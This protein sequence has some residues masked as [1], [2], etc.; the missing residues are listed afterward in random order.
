MNLVRKDSVLPAE[1]GVIASYPDDFYGYFGWPTVARMPGG[2]LVA[3]ASGLRNHHVCPFGRSV[4]FRS[5]DEGRSWTSPR[6]V[7][8]SPLDDRDTGLVS[9]GGERLLLTWFT[10]DLRASA[11]KRMEGIDAA[12]RARWQ[13]GIARIDDDNAARWVGAWCRIS[14]DAGETWSEPIKVPQTTP[15]GPIR[16][17]AG[18]LLFLGK[19]FETDMAGFKGGVGAI[20]ATR[21]QDG[22]RT[23][24]PLG[25]VPL[26]E[27]STEQNYHEAHVAELPDG[28]LVGLIRFERGGGVDPEDL[29]LQDFIHMYTESTDGGR[30]W[31]RSEPM[32]FHGCPPHLL[33]HSSG[34]LVCA[35]GR[36]REPFGER[37]MISRDGG[38]TWEYD[39]VLR[40]D[41]PDSD[42]GYPSSVE[43]DDGSILTAYYQKP[44]TAR[45]KCAFLWS[46]WRLPGESS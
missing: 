31:T 22:G 15:H 18:G 3:A 21:S 17:R 33:V 10:T 28:K 7:N 37:V 46:R 39:Y 11:E 19:L 42:L 29:G 35:Y 40:D 30:T 13:E 8:D 6:V 20:V 24:Q 5:T 12:T 44:A 43:L 36:R 4:F 25:T 1:H 23:W 34:A 27:G 16:L 9:C 45:D 38:A 26:Y 41:G 32:D 2:T 14:E